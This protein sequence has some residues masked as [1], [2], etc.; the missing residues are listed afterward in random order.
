MSCKKFMTIFGAILALALFAPHARA[1]EENQASQFTFNQPVELP[2]HIVLPAGTYWFQVA[3]DQGSMGNN[4]IVQVLS[5]D[6][7]QNY[8]SFL[9]ISAI[10]SITDHSRMTFAERSHGK[11][12]ALVSWFYPDRVFGH[13]FVYPSHEEARLSADVQVDVRARIAGQVYGG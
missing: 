12:M 9:T 3:N 8:G 13:E 11:P 7:S 2:G 4:N 6:R 5:A 10:H 1:D